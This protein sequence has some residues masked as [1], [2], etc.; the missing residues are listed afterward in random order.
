MFNPK[1]KDF[2]KEHKDLTLIGLWWAFYWRVMLVV[3]AIYF[4]I[5]ML[6]IASSAF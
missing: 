6:A 2:L 4:V 1:V 5:G 3:L